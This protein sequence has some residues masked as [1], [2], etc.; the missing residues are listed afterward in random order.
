MHVIYRIAP[1]WPWTT[2]NQDF[3]VTPLF[4]A[5]YPRNDARYRHKYNTTRD[6]HTAYWRV[7]FQMTSSDFAKYSMTRSIARSL[8]DSWA[9]YFK[10]HPRAFETSSSE[11]DS[12]TERVPLTRPH[13]LPVGQ[14]KMVDITMTSRI[15]KLRAL[16]ARVTRRVKTKYD[17][18]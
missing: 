4:D 8:W 16:R 11:P 14:R 10:T 5:E 3:K 12:Q 15:V 9:S 17:V 1:L 18:C 6:L 2:H 7:S 13:Y